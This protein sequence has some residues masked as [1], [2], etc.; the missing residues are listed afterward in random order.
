VP[1]PVLEHL[2]FEFKSGE[3]LAL[4]LGVSRAAVHKAIYALEGVGIPLERSRAGYRLKPGTPAKHLLEPQL[5]GSFGHEY[6]YLGSVDSTQNAL[7]VQAEAGTLEGAVILSETQ[8]GGRGRRGRKWQSP[9]GMGLYFSLLLRPNLALERLPLIS[10]AAGVALAEVCV[11][12]QL[13]W[14]NDLLA[15]D[16]RK[17]A[18]ILLEG[19]IRGEELRYVL[20]GIGL[21]I[22]QTNSLQSQSPNL[23]ATRSAA[24]DEFQPVSRLEL[25]CDLLEALERW[26]YAPPE[27][28]LHAWKACSCTLGR[29]VRLPGST[30]LTS[31]RV[32]IAKDL[33]SSGALLVEVDGQLER[34]SAG[35][36]ELVGV[37]GNSLE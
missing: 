9:P 37:L 28:I 14:P 19:D 26:V 35:D 36:V 18:G 1:N 27:R 32:G 2:L 7:R 29:E 10:L 23:S 33:D 8:T 25:L 24:L 4:E 20:L 3:T 34:I 30:E 22:H 13:K 31:P 16:G 15:S 17:L 11:H 12:G 21:N 5:K 6:S